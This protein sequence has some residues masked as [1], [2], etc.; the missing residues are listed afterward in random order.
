M[1][2]T[3]CGIKLSVDWKYC[4]SCGKKV[5]NLEVVVVEQNVIIEEILVE[6]GH[7]KGTG[8]CRQGVTGDSGV[9][10]SCPVCRD[11][12]GLT[13]KWYEQAWAVAVPCSKCNGIGK[14]RVN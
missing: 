14:R 8:T 2:C 7:C 13:F 5:D 10:Y 4:A 6:C 3:N 12:S 9:T 11:K 1:N